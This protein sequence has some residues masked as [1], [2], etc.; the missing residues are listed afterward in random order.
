MLPFLD[1]HEVRKHLQWDALIA[2]MEKALIDFSAGRV[3]QPVRRLLPIER[4]G[5]FFGVMPAVSADAMGAKLVTFYPGNAARG[6]P[7]HLAVILLFAPETGEALARLDGRLITEMRTAA[8][9]AAATKALAAPDA[10]VLAILGSGVQ[11]RAH[12]DALKRVRAFAEIRV[13]SRTPAHAERFAEEVGARVM[14]AEDAVRGADVI[15]TAT[16]TKAPIL[17]GAWLK[18]GAHVNAI[19]WGGYTSRELDDAAMANVVVVELREAALDQCGDVILSGAEIYAELGE[20]LGGGQASAGRTDHS[21]RFGRHRGRGHRGRPA[22]LRGRGGRQGMIDPYGRTRELGEPALAAMVARLE[23]RGGHRS[24]AAM[25]HAYLDRLPLASARSVL[26][27][28]CGTGVAARAVASRPEFAGRVV[29]IDLSPHMVAAARRR[30][31]EQGLAERITFQI[32]DCLALEEV[33]AACDIVIAHTL[34]SHVPAPDAV[35]A[36]AARVVRPGGTV[37]IFDIDPASLTF[38]TED[39]AYG[40]RMEAAIS[41]ALLAHPRLMRTMPLL[42]RRAGLE[43]VDSLAWVISEIGT[44]DFWVGALD[45]FLVLVPEAGVLSP[46]EIQAFVDAQRRASA[47][48]TFFASANYYAYLARRSA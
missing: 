25:L 14:A 26:D 44:G 8:V 34:M 12:V 4:H 24:F 7:T 38:G 13:W 31:H 48:G 33:D 46:D 47:E 22:G 37:A 28:G 18:P 19:G 43:L 5:G 39:P 11:A 3:Q 21:V 29:G 36:E 41:A 17:E 27:L 6:M 15:V 40:A 20:I 16:A 23:Q 9:S 32:G 35:L 42:L 10:K 30:A 2:A 1:E 45:S